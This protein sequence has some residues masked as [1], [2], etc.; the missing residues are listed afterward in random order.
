MDE[1]EIKAEDMS[2]DMSITTSSIV[3]K[4]EFKEEIED[5]KIEVKEEEE[6]SRSQ[7]AK[8]RRFY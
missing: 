2:T 3:V 5:E 1:I 8:R 6:S 4:R 7:R